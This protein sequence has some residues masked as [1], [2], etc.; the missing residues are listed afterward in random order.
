MGRRGAGRA[1]PTTTATVGPARVDRRTKELAKRLHAGDIAVVDHEDLDRVAVRC[2]IDAGVRAVVNAAKSSSGRYPNEGPLLLAAAGIVLVDDVGAGVMDLVREGAPVG[3]D[4]A[5]VVVDGRVVATGVRQDLASLERD[6]LAAKATMGLALESFAA[7]TLEFLR[8]EQ[9]AALHPPRLP[10]LRT[11]FAGR[12]VLLVVRGPDYKEDLAHL[13]SYVREVRP[14]LI[15]VDGG[16]DALLE[17]GLRPDLII[18][19]FDSVSDRA[20]TGKSELV[21]HAYPDGLAPGAARLDQ[22]GAAYVTLEAAG[23]SE[24]VAMLLAYDLGAEL[25]VAVGAHGSMVEFLEKGRAG[26][27]STFLTRLKIG[28]LLVDAK[29]V[30]K[31]YGTRVR[32]RDL[33]AFLAAA[34]LCFVVVVVAVLP[35]VFLDSIWFLLGDFW[36]SVTD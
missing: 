11:A 14:L 13:R 26:M 9:H 31:L 7:N 29:G 1:E 4:G 10:E 28:Q 24:D 8:E 2:L 35:N 27:A 18:G 12:H 21:V 6:Y 20:L 17:C 3:V 23:T 34:M 19:D 25:I 32:K 5:E 30:S 33:A 16:A 36:R 22:A 15:G